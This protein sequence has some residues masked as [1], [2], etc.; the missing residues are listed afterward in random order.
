[1]VRGSVST[2]KFIPSSGSIHLPSSVFRFFRTFP[3]PFSLGVCVW[4]HSVV[5]GLFPSAM[6]ERHVVD[7]IREDFIDARRSL[8]GVKWGV[9]SL[10][11]SPHDA[12][13]PHC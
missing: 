9:L 13:P 1:V 3:V 5:L 7:V 8:D 12:N 10:E 2:L 4:K 6:S 11:N